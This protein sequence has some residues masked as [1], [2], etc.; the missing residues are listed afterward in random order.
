MSLSD[1]NI[2]DSMMSTIARVFKKRILTLLIGSCGKETGIV[3]KETAVSV[4]Q[5]TMVE[6]DTSYIG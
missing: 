3:L 6:V 5:N 4:K 2:T 1:Q